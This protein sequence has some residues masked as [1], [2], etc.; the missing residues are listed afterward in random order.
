MA[1]PGGTGAIRHAFCNY[2]EAGDQILLTDWYWAAYHTIADENRRS[3]VTFPLYNEAGTFNMIAYKES[4]KALLKKQKRVLSVLNTPAHNPTGYTITDSEWDEIIAFVTEEANNDPECKIILLV[5]LAYIDF[6]G[7]G[8]EARAF[9]KKLTGMPHNVLTLYAFSCSKGYTMYGLRN[10]AIICVAPTL[11][12]AEE[13]AN[14]CT[15]SNRGSWS[16]GTRGAMETISKIYSDAKLY[17]QMIDEQN[18]YKGI[19]RNRAKA[20]VEE[21][22]K[23]GLEIVTYSDGF[24]ISIPCEYSREIS[25][26]LMDKNVFIVGLAKGLRFAPCAVSE[27]KCRRAPALILEAM[28]EVLSEKA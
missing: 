20:F 18:Y 11:A 23:V 3:I 13:F 4:M 10:G 7:E 12:I 6:S 26:R 22:K 17:Q 24:F 25:D 9:M 28:N 5:D 15:Y 27:E 14:A 8:D 16:N 19:L 21:A 2:T 1:T